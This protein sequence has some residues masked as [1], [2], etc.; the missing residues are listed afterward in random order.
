VLAAGRDAGHDVAMPDICRICETVVLHS[1]SRKAYGICRP[2]VATLAL[3]PLP[4][5]RRPA[6]PCT[7]CN[8]RRFVRAVPRVKDIQRDL[9][10]GELEPVM[11]RNA[12]TG[13]VVVHRGPLPIGERRADLPFAVDGLGTLEAY[14]C[15]QCGYVEWYCWDPMKI[16][17][18]PEYMT[19]VVD[20]AGDTP[21]R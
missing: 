14:V 6:I 9:A 15:T 20:Y 1:E 12:L 8:C 11:A 19:D 4:P 18:G 7:R 21:Y 17:I 13:P 2:C 16:P 5:P 10:S 3:A